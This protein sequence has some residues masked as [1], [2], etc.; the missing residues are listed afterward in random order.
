MSGSDDR[1]HDVKAS[2]DRQDWSMLYRHVALLSILS[3]L[4]WVVLT[5]CGLTLGQR[6]AYFLSNNG[7]LVVCPWILRI[8]HPQ[9]FGLQNHWVHLPELLLQGNR[10]LLDNDSKNFSWHSHYFYLLKPLVELQTSNEIRKSGIPVFNEGVVYSWYT[11]YTQLSIAMT[12]A[13]YDWLSCIEKSFRRYILIIF[14][15]NKY[16]NCWQK[17]A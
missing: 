16:N 1:P 15:L 7:S 11:N 3:H 17:P 9:Q 12:H 6:A 4:W 14:P 5:L 2:A 10:R 8:K 13:V